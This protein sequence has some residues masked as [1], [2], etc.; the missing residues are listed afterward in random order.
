MAPQT[1]SV[2]NVHSRGSFMHFGRPAVLVHMCCRAT[3]A[4]VLRANGKPDF[5]VLS[6]RATVLDATHVGAPLIST[7]R[8]CSITRKPPTNTKRDTRRRMTQDLRSF[9]LHNWRGWAGRPTILPRGRLFKYP[10]WPA[11]PTLVPGLVT[12]FSGLQAL[13]SPRRPVGFAISA[14]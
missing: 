11:L 12:S 10:S 4:S 13:P 1:C 5:G 9:A 8:P 2:S 6:R 14:F 3:R 7:G